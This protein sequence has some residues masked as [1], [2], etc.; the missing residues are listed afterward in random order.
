MIHYFNFLNQ[1]LLSLFICLKSLFLHFKIS[2]LPLKLLIL[3]DILGVIFKSRSWIFYCLS[4]WSR[5]LRW[6]S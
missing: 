3:I 1:G 6:V 4:G 5:Y 2:F